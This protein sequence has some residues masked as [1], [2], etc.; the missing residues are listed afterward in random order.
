M[1]DVCQ[2][3][4]QD[5]GLQPVIQGH[6]SVA[7][8]RLAGLHPVL[9]ELTAGVGA[10]RVAV[11]A[12]PCLPPLPAPP[13]RRRQDTG[14]RPQHTQDAAVPAAGHTGGGGDATSRRRGS[15]RRK[16][17]GDSHLRVRRSQNGDFP[18]GGGLVQ[19]ERVKGVVTSGVLWLFWFFLTIAGIVPFYTKIHQEEYNSSLFMFALYYIYFALVLT[20]LVLHSFADRLGRHGYQFL[21]QK[22]S[23][24]VLASFP[25][26]LVFWWINSLVVR[27][28]R[29]GLTQDDLFDLHPRDQSARVVPEFQAAWEREL[30]RAD[31]RNRYRMYNTGVTATCSEGVTGVTDTRLFVSPHTDRATHRVA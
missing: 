7:G 9:P 23:P 31:K 12:P 18:A 5:E 16:E 11:A 10:M 17:G 25:S 29:H 8:Q 14:E 30:Q 4:I 21:G 1:T 24:E 22:P 26:R 28:Y 6:K 15:G 13:A 19:V 27:A 20:Q 2:V 3:V